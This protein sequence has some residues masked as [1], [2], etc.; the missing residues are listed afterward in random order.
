MVG[1]SELIEAFYNEG[2]IDEFIVTLFPKILGS[3][4]PLKTLHKAIKK[5]ELIKKKSTDY[6]QGVLQEHYL[7]KK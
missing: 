1:G 3:G 7:V 4:V 2:F 5:D 6:G